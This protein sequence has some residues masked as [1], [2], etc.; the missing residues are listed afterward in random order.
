MLKVRKE[1]LRPFWAGRDVIVRFRI[2]KWTIE[3]D[4]R[5]IT[6]PRAF[7]DSGGFRTLERRSSRDPS[8][9]EGVG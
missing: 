5:L 2:R 1:S 8:R 6:E 4:D 9:R 7:D 3:S